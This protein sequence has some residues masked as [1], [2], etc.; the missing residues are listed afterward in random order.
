MTNRLDRQLEFII[1][2]DRVK[3]VFRKSKQFHQDRYENDAEHSWHIAL[4]AMV[5]AEHA[6][7]K[8]D[9]L[10]VIKM[11][12]IHDLVEIDTGDTIVYRKNEE[13]ERAEAAAAERI[14]GILPV[15]QGRKF[16]DLWKEFEA[17]E[18]AEAR[19]A[20]AV[21]RLEPLMQNIYRRG[22]TWRENNVSAENVKKVNS[23]IGRSSRVLW[24]YALSEIERC[25]SEGFL[26]D[27]SN[28]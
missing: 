2:V 25:V 10:R 5:L 21:D 26:P 11:L 8:P 18:T 28:E 20:L 1:E 6:D 15:E 14:F 13:T 7:G 19:F 12:L 9:I 17:G 3:D 4:M 27:R 23:R 24:E 16:L 22:E